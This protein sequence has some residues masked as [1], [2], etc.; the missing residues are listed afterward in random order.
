[1]SVDGVEWLVSGRRVWSA[2]LRVA[3]EGLVRCR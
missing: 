2:G 1:M 3:A